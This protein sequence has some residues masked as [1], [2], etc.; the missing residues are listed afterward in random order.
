M[1]W[2]GKSVLI[3]GGTGF[4]GSH[5]MEDLALRGALVR[6]V[7]SRDADL[8]IQARCAELF[9]RSYDVVFHLA[10]H[11]GGIGANL[12]RP[13]QMLYDNA[14]M[15]LNV[16]DCAARGDVGKLVIAGTVCSYPKYT[17]VPFREELLWDGYPEETNAPYGIAKR[18]LY[19]AVDAYRRQ[20]GTNAIVVLPANLYGPRDNFDLET[21]HVIPALIRKFMDAKEHGDKRVVLWGDGT[22]TREFLYVADAVAGMI[23]AAERY[24]APMPLNLGTGSEIPIVFVARMIRDMIA[25]EIDIAWDTSKPNGQPRRSLDTSRATRDI[26]WTASTPLLDGLERTI[27]WYR[28]ARRATESL[29]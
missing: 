27:E 7:G 11:C 1:N 25:P 10:A 17:R 9:T 8:T 24:D 2:K 28:G 14:M 22:P 15:G 18:M 20:Y 21:S 3:T 23:A 29:P 5:L 13:A 16:L 19:T 26:G 4:V 6:S 12:A